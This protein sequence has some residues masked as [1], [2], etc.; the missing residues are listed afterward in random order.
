MP[1]P[2][3]LAGAAAVAIGTGIK[4]GIDGFKDNSAAKDITEAAESLYDTEKK[5]FD[6]QDAATNASLESLGQLQLSIGSDFAEFKRISELLLEKLA[7][8]KEAKDLQINIPKNELDKIE[9]IAFSAVAY[10]G[11]LAG[12]A[13]IGAGA[14]YAVYG[15]VMAL[16]AASTGTPIA[17]LS[18]AAAYKATMAAIGGGAISAGGFGMAGGAA[19]LG[20]AVVAPIVLVAGLAFAKHSEKKLESARDYRTQVKNAVSSMKL[21]RHHLKETEEYSNKIYKELNRVYQIFGQYFQD[22]KNMDTLVRNGVDINTISSAII[23]IVDNGYKVA[24]ILT[25]I[26]TTPLFK[27][28]KDDNG[29]LVKNKEDTVEFETDKDGMKVINKEDIDAHITLSTYKSKDFE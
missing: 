5:L 24:A 8:H 11:Q 4:K 29:E 17:A 27:P 12:G 1:L 28:K 19:I 16:A 3:I 13:A 6:E 10:L 15:G 26:I 22:L 25:D 9:G 7:Q 20:G 2:F 18:G 21:G 14:A 23:K